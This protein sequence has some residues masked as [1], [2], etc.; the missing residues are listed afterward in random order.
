MRQELNPVFSSEDKFRHKPRC[1][2]MVGESRTGKSTFVNGFVKSAAREYEKAFA[3]VSGDDIRRVLRVRYDP[4]LEDQVRALTILMA[5][6]MMV[7]LQN[8]VID[9]TNL[10]TSDRLRWINLAVR[11]GFD[12][13][14]CE[15]ETLPI[16][17]HRK[18]CEEHGYDWAVIEAQKR[19]RQV[20]QPFEYEGGGY[21]LSAY[22]E[23]TR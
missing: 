12:F 21:H 22:K 9:E 23:R 15:M 10:E 14:I 5:D 6:S 19:R 18:S 20:V 8:V 3:I 4:K 16:E 7:R 13:T 11:Y 1:I 17:I 2:I